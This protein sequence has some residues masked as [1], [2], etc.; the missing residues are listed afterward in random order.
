M[1]KIKLRGKYQKIMGFVEKELYCSA[2]DLDHVMRVYN[3][4][5]RIAKDEKNVDLDVLKS[6]TLLH[7]IAR[8]KED[9]DKSGKTCHAME[10]ANMSEKI[11]ISLNYP[12]D[13]IEKIKKCI[14]SHRYK[15]ESRAQTIEEKI[16]FDADKLDSLGA[17]V[18]MRAGMWLGRNNAN[19]FPK[20]TLEKYIK[21]NLV[22]GKINGRIKDAS[23][24]CIYYEHEIKNKKLPGAMHTKSGKKIAKERLKFLDKFLDRLKKEAEGIL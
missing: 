13:K 6:A 8:V 15:T 18:I 17:I 22:G 1:E 24:H 7:D 3:M 12:K 16:L 5:L 9:N 4:A 23:K 2:H 21:E 14:L 11:L 20:M 19:I 10:S